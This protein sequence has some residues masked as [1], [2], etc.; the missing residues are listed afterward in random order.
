MGSLV[1]LTWNVPW[2]LEA[3]WRMNT[4]HAFSSLEAAGR[5]EAFRGL[6]CPGHLPPS[7]THPS[8]QITPFSGASQRGASLAAKV[9]PQLPP[10]ASPWDIGDAQPSRPCPAPKPPADLELCGGS[11]LDF[12]GVCQGKD[13]TP[14]LLPQPQGLGF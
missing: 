9:T 4:A 10:G 2:G 6:G 7:C 14:S 8:P 1:S 3:A 5:A 11:P 13:A 12:G